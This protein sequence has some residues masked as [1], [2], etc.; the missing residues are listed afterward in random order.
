M[1]PKTTHVEAHLGLSLLILLVSLGN[2]KPFICWY[3]ISREYEWYRSGALCNTSWKQALQKYWMLCDGDIFFST[4]FALA[5]KWKLLLLVSWWRHQMETF[6]ALLALVR[7]IHRWPVN[8]P[9]KGRWRGALVFSLIC[10][11]T[12]GWVN[13][14]NADDLRCHRAHYDVT[15][16]GTICRSYHGTTRGAKA[17]Y[18][19]CMPPYSVRTVFE[20]IY[21]I[22]GQYERNPVDNGHWILCTQQWWMFQ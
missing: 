15:V 8:S 18:D 22:L 4:A 12:N 13:N 10:V 11:W 6:S 7:E 2:K 19:E 9:Y 20:S 14:R 3:Y 5:S 1:T 16:M 21:A 17:I